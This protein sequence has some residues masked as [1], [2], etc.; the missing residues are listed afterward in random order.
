MNDIRIAI[1]LAI[2]L[3]GVLLLLLRPWRRS[4]EAVSSTA[5]REDKSVRPRHYI[6]FPQI[7]QALS[8]ADDDYLLQEAPPE[9]AKQARRERRA[10]AR[11]FLRGLKQDFADLEQLG[12]MIAGLSPAVSREQETERWMLGLKFQLLYVIVLFSLFTGNIPLHRIENLT[13]LI[14]RL[15]IRIDRAMEQISELPARHNLRGINA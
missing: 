5:Y 4:R 2:A 7:Q 11:S 8:K 9:V 6:Y 3:F 10:V 1:P 13:E 14:G 12:R 15:A